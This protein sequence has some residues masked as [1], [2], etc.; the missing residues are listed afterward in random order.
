MRE[1]IA[2]SGTW[3]GKGRAHIYDNVNTTYA[4]WYYFGSIAANCAGDI[5][6]GFSGSSA[7]NNLSAFYWYR[8]ANGAAPG[9]A[10]LLQAGLT[11]YVNPHVGD[12]TAT[13]SDPFDDFKFWSVQQYAD[14]TAAGDAMEDPWKTVIT[15]IR[16]V[17]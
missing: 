12:Y 1:S 6:L 2:G 16:P 4:F 9:A 5:V 15:E 3:R 13:V 8:T 7:S 11:N 14:P 17:P 10:R